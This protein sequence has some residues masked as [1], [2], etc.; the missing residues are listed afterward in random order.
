M[1]HNLVTRVKMEV[2]SKGLT[3]FKLKWTQ[4]EEQTDT[5]RE[6][7]GTFS[8]GNSVRQLDRTKEEAIGQRERE[9]LD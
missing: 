2:I 5:M 9:S 1:T 4:R 7:L 8:T 3:R 6:T